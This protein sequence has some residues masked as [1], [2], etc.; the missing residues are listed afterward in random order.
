VD[1]L[2][3]INKLPKRELSVY[4]LNKENTQND[5]ETADSSN[6]KVKPVQ[7]IFTAMKGESE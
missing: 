3:R 6:K 5:Y 2:L 1:A 4:I 7:K